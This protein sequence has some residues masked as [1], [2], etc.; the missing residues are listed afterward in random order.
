M[1][2]SGTPDQSSETE[3][4]TELSEREV[5]QSE[6]C[7]QRNVLACEICGAPTGLEKSQ[8]RL[9]EIQHA[10]TMQ[11]PLAEGAAVQLLKYENT[12]RSSD[13]TFDITHLP[14]KR[15]ARII[16]RQTVHNDEVAVNK[17]EKIS[18]NEIEKSEE[19]YQAKIDALKSAGKTNVE[20]IQI[21]AS[22]PA[23]QKVNVPNWFNLFK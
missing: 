8:A 12:Q 23:R 16:E 7:H 1:Y 5:V 20:I 9:T 19:T 15:L 6:C 13:P 2:Q 21:L 3:I 10:I 22:D 17:S 11:P 4:K 18:A 14:S